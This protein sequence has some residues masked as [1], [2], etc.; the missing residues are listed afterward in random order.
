MA[1]H[2]ETG[3]TIRTIATHERGAVLDLLDEWISREFFGRYFE[4]DP[5]FRDDLC[6]VALD[7]D[8]I[9]STL[10]VFGKD[11]RLG[12]TTVRVGG[13]GNVFTTAAYRERHAAS[14]LLSLAI[15]AMDEQGFDLSLLFASRLAF[16]GRHGWTSHPR[17]FV[18]IDRGAASI[19]GAYSIT[20]FAMERDLAAVMTVYDTYCETLAGTT[21]RDRRYWNGQLRYAGNFDEDFLVARASD[22]IV[23]YA[24]AATLYEHYVIMEHAYLPGHAGA[25]TDLVCRL[26]SQEGAALAGTTSHLAVEPGVVQELAAR[27][28]TL[29]TIDDVFWM[30]R[31][32]SPTRLARKLG[33]SPDAVTTDD[34]LPSLLPA[35]RSVFWL[36]DRF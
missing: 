25:F 20:R 15:A 33:V 10:Q 19:S 4:H 32:I 30:W 3:L 5:A 35:D 17:Q 29:R 34:F 11:V 22:R 14:Q 21:R 9:V 1:E 23:A 24:R 18:F 13:V 31:V 8:R 28:L 2:A 16:Y 27:G 36:S 7:G 26:H 6:F 12:G